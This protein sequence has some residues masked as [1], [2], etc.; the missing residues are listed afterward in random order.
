MQTRLTCL[1]SVTPWIDFMIPS[2]RRVVIPSLHRQVP[3]RLDRIVLLDHPLDAVRG[4]DQLVDPHPA[5]VPGLVADVAPLRPGEHE[6]CR[7]RGCSAS[8]TAPRRNFGRS[9]RTQSGRDGMTSL[10]F[11]QR[12]RTRRW[13]RIPRR[14][15]AKLSGSIPMSRRRTIVSGALFV[16]SVLKTRWPV[17]DASTPVLAVSKSRISPTMITSGSARRKARMAAAKSKPILDWTW[18]CLRPYWV[19]STGSSAVQIFRSGRLISWRAA[20]SVVVFPEPV[21]PT[22][23]IIP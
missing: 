21:G 16:W 7:R 23:R 2:C 17:S 3:H 1:K 4:D 22:H 18:T 13:A 19:I 5:L 9:R 15:S 20:C 6:T 8:G 12:V 14:A 10:H 11:L